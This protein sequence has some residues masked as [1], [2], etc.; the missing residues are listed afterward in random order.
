MKTWPVR[1]KL[2]IFALLLIL[3]AVLLPATA[4]AASDPANTVMVI[5]I[6]GEITPAMAAFL[7]DKINEANES[8][9]LGIIIDI[10]TFG[11]RVDAAV[12]MRD[13]ILSSE[14]PVVVYIR[15][16]RHFGRRPD[17][18]RSGYDR[19]GAGQPPGSRQAQPV[20][21]KDGR[22]CQRRVPDNR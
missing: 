21:F 22:L 17:L 1:S 11:G 19:D 5:P 18:H 13:A 6:D 7:E 3:L 14:V 9:M 10:K 15:E 12:E 20:G 16:P 2:K 8:G 4:S